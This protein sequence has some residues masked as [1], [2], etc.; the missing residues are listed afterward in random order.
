MEFKGAAQVDKDNLQK[1][2]FNYVELKD[3]YDKKIQHCKD[4]LSSEIN[5]LSW[6][7]KFWRD[8]HHP[9][10]IVVYKNVCKGVMKPYGNDWFENFNSVGLLSEEFYDKYKSIYK[11]LG[12]YEGVYAELSYLNNMSGVV[13]VTPTQAYFIDKFLHIDMKS[14][15]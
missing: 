9:D 12:D 15:R 3:N 7:D 10:W 11:V 1:A 6:W 14:Y 2:L 5:T 13:Y 4:K 8:E